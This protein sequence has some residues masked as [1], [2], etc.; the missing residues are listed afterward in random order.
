[1]TMNSASPPP[2]R[3]TPPSPHSLL[4]AE[5]R[6]SL[7]TLLAELESDRTRGALAQEKLSQ[8]EIG[9]LFS[10]PAQRHVKRR[11]S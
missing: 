5:V 6:Y 3:P 7:P 8:E 9:A 10:A 2:G 4:A 11:R 1:M